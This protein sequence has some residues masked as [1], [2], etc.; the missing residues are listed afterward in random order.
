MAGL[1][2]AGV[3]GHAV[4]AGVLVGTALTLNGKR[5]IERD[6]VHT[7][8][9]LGKAEFHDVG[10]HAPEGVAGTHV[11][12]PAHGERAAA[13]AAT[14]AARSLALGTAVGHVGQVVGL[15]LG[16]GQPA[17]KLTLKAH[18][19][20]VSVE[21]R[22]LHPAPGLLPGLDNA[23]VNVEGEALLMEQAHDF[24]AVGHEGVGRDGD[25]HRDA[26]VAHATDVAQHLPE[27]AVA[28][29]AL[30]GVLARAVERDLDARSRMRRKEVDHVLVDE[31]AVGEDGDLD[32]HA[33]KV[34]VELLETRVRRALATRE[35]CVHHASVDGL[36]H[37]V[38]P[39]LD[40][41]RFCAVELVGIEMDIAHL[42]IEVAQRRELEGAGDGDVLLAS[43]EVHEPADLAIT[44]K[45]GDALGVEVVEELAQ[46]VRREGLRIGGSCSS[47]GLGAGVRGEL[48]RILLDVCHGLSPESEFAKDATAERPEPAPGYAYGVGHHPGAA[49]GARAVGVERDGARA[50]F[51]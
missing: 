8:P 10:R 19:V 30:V 51:D 20:H 11:A 36:G 18:H 41:K 32:A 3:L 26:R 43:L 5:V 29:D 25:A 6:R 35:A 9:A 23:G 22:V 1:G 45:V 14:H 49:E 4:L 17:L 46:G 42:A 24:E 44:A 37:D 50:T 33:G 40:V 39:G 13:G 12:L 28:C 2:A 16:L 31:D 34:Q 47:G 27:H 38:L 48:G 15:A 21:A 7:P